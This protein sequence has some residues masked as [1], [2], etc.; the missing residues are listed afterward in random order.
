MRVRPKSLAHQLQAR[1]PLNIAVFVGGGH[2][3]DFV[4]K[5]PFIQAIRRVFPRSHL[6]WL[7]IVEPQY[8]DFFQ[9]AFP[10]VH[11]LP[12]PDRRGMRVILSNA[13]LFRR[14]RARG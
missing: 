8:Q 2:L 1:E 7:G 6:F 9:H 13:T 3:G 5:V 14:L 12:I 10:S 11:Q 4:F